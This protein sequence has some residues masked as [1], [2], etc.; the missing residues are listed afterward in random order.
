G[1][2]IASGGNDKTVRMWDATSGGNVSIYRGH[3]EEV[4]GVTW[5]PDSRYIASA[6]HDHTVRVWDTTNGGNTFIY[7]GHSGYVW[8]VAWSPD[9]KRIAS[10]AGATFG[11]TVTVNDATVQVW[12]APKGGHIYIYGGHSYWVYVFTV[13]WSPDGQSIASGSN[14]GTVLVWN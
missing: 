1:Q 11:E 6:S 7:Q 4:G 14:D 5:S 13:A 10:S 12:D 3:T 8:D 9:G 2:R